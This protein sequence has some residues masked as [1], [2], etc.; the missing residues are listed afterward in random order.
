MGQEALTYPLNCPLTCPVELFH[1]GAWWPVSRTSGC[2]PEAA[3]APTCCCSS[4]PGPTPAA[5][6]AAPSLKS[7]PSKKTTGCVERPRE[8]ACVERSSSP[9]ECRRVRERATTFVAHFPTPLN[10]PQLSQQTPLLFLEHQSQRISPCPWAG[11][12][13]ACGKPCCFLLGQA[14]RGQGA[15]VA[16][17]PASPLQAPAVA[18]RSHPGG[19]KSPLRPRSASRLGHARWQ[20]QR[21]ITNDAPRGGGVLVVSVVVRACSLGEAGAPVMAGGARGCTR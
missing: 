17:Q 21:A 3:P 15:R 14:G 4:P 11:V 5:T 1:E 9:G 2:T 20:R 16:G 8:C 7:S 12:H 18:P 19:D 13:P 10:Y 6:R